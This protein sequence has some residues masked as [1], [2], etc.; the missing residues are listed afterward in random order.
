MFSKYF[1]VH[2]KIGIATQNYALPPFSVA[3]LKVQS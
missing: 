1:A 2:F 3:C